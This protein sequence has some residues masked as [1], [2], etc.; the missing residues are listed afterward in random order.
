M[1]LAITSKS[2][3]LNADVERRFADAPFF[4]IVDTETLTFK[5][6]SIKT[7]K[8]Y[9]QKE[10]EIARKISREKVDAVLTGLCSDN[11]FQIFRKSSIM[12]YE[13]ANGKVKKQVNSFIH[14][15]LQPTQNLNTSKNLPFWIIN[16]TNVKGNH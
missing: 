6:F 8:D 16:K 9:K 14:D 5:S 12:V 3:D 7:N 4:L 10:I 13:T 1:K 15:W 2:C 11:A